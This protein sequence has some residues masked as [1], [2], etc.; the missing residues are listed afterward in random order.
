VYVIVCY[1]LLYTVR[2][3]CVFVYIW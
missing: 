3:G 1:S 2:D